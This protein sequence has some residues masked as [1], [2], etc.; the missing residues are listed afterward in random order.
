MVHQVDAFDRVLRDLQ[1]GDLQLPGES[2]DCAS[3]VRRVQLFY[4]E[5]N[6]DS[7][8]YEYVVR[9]ESIDYTG[10]VYTWH[11]WLKLVHA[12][13][14]HILESFI[15]YVRRVM[16]SKPG[17]QPRRGF[18]ASAP[19]NGTRQ[20]T[21]VTP[22]AYHATFFRDISGS[23]CNRVAYNQALEDLG[24][25]GR[26]VDQVWY[27]QHLARTRQKSNVHTLRTLDRSVGFGPKLRMD[28]VHRKMQAIPGVG[29][30]LCVAIPMDN[31]S[32]RHTFVI[33]KRTGR[34]SV[35]LDSAN[36][37]PTEYTGSSMEWVLSWSSIRRVWIL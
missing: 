3:A 35:V 6:R 8:T 17:D 33:T 5:Y 2:E 12:D 14:P 11:E 30:Y 20:A 24:C 37:H 21:T 10:S 27:K 36:T 31:H 34:P 22:A 1:S 26:Q 25:M 32:L 28:N 9:L 4:R 23:D 16:S 18:R 15:R 29:T 19:D 7:K 13:I